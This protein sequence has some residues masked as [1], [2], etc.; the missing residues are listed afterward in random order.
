MATSKTTVPFAESP[1]AALRGLGQSIW[2]DFIRRNMITGGDLARLV[3]QD[4]VAGVTSNPTIFEKAITGSDDY[5]AQIQEI[6]RQSPELPARAL[7]E[8][9]V[10]K[11]IQDVADILRGVHDRTDGEDGYVSLEVSPGVANDTEATIAEAR[12][13]WDAVGRPNVMIK[14]PGTA[15]GVPAVRALIAEGVNVNITLLFGQKMYEAVA[16][17]YIEGLEARRARS[18]AAGRPSRMASVASF[19]VSRI[20]TKVDALLDEKLKAAR[21]PDRARLEGLL[22]KVAIAN[23][24]VAYQI[25]E[26]IVSG[27]R[28]QALAAGGTGARPQRLLWASTSVKNPRYR[29][30]MYVEELIGPDTIDTMPLETLSA[31]RDH[32]R[33]R[34]SLEADLDGAR[35]TLAD[36]EDVGISLQKVTDE[37]VEE[38]VRKF[39]E[40]FDKLLGAL[41]RRRRAGS[42]SSS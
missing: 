40:P 26:G 30:V 7:Y 39:Q 1:L 22:G 19:F 18:G 25:Y 2:L 37:L 9:L 35:R 24:R 33:V 23:A 36:L 31:F 42:G 10:V 38:G 21:G 16:W 20:D 8:R 32:G 4:G 6:L 12:H 15:A 11:D 3:E 41:E 17:A 27:A 14:V 34:P 13:L 29:D 28:W 5:D